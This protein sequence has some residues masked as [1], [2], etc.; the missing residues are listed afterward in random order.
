MGKKSLAVTKAASAAAAELTKFDALTAEAKRINAEAQ[1]K[2]SVQFFFN[3]EVSEA[4]VVF[5]DLAL[6]FQTKV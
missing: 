6:R 4:Q 2:R 5:G 3:D 1:I